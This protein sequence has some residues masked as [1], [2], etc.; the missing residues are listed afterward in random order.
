M[1]LEAKKILDDLAGS[2]G[3]IAESE[4]QEVESKFL[5]SPSHADGARS[6]AVEPISERADALVASIEG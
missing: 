5:E 4:R 6:G 1:N 3:G 2:I